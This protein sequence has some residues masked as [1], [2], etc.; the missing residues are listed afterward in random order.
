MKRTRASRHTPTKLKKM[1]KMTEQPHLGNTRLR[2]AAPQSR[3]EGSKISR[4]GS[5]LSSQHT[6][7]QPGI[8]AN[9]V[10]ILSLNLVNFCAANQ[11]PVVP[12]S[13]CAADIFSHTCYKTCFGKQG[14]VIRIQIANKAHQTFSKVQLFHVNRI[15]PPSLK[16][17][18][19]SPNSSTTQ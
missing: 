14:Y 2:Q 3:P 18:Y 7:L 13:H 12:E 11:S 10:K 8:W 16:N 17:D 1:Q 4:R 5:T 9:K 19:N 6:F 15:C